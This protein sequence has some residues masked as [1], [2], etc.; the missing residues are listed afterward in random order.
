MIVW[1]KFTCSL[2]SRFLWQ[3]E[4]HFQI[5][6]KF[7]IFC[8]STLCLQSHH[9]TNTNFK[10]SC[11]ESF[12]NCVFEALNCAENSHFCKFLSFVELTSIL[13]LQYIQRRNTYLSEYIR[14]LKNYL[15]WNKIWMAYWCFKVSQAQLCSILF[16]TLAFM[17]F[18]TSF[19]L[20]VHQKS[21]KWKYFA[22]YFELFAHESSHF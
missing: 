21:S 10:L 19:L 13:L 22:K 5:F 8:I 2:F 3:K 20:N 9:K 1:N 12:K 17:A 7:Q 4:G 18:N 15:F 14:C 16:R 11:F 6:S